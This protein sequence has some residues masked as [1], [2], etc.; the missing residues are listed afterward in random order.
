E[1]N[2]PLKLADGP[3]DE[4]LDRIPAIDIKRAHMRPPRRE[5]ISPIQVITASNIRRPVAHLARRILGLEMH[6]RPVRPPQ[7]S[8]SSSGNHLQPP[9]IAHH[10]IPAHTREFLV[11][12]LQRPPPHV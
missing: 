9:L 4:N 10:P 1:S 12:L 2:S 7:C 8:T 11:Q 6:K 3:G 5:N